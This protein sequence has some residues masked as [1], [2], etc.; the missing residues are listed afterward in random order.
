MTESVLW[1]TAL[2]MFAGG[3]ALLFM[4]KRRNETEGVMSLAH[5]IVP[6]I[7]GCLY[8][9]MA[10]GQGAVLLPTDATLAGAANT[11]RIFWFGRYID[12]VFTTP[13]L[14]VSLGCLGMLQGRK[15][16]DLL[17]G[18]V[19]A[20][21]LMIVTAFA[22][23]A[24]ENVVS[25]WIWFILSCVA[26]LGVYYVIWVSQMEAN[27]KE[28]AEVQSAYKRSATILSVLWMV[29]PVILAISPDG[30]GLVADSVSVLVIAI[31]DVL[32]KVAFGFLSLSDDR[33]LERA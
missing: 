18:A 9:A 19:T 8:V 11:T 23:S 10:T 3:T 2:I 7:A 28:S 5:G 30:L 17:L 6:I 29:Y 13:L 33:K 15:R 20:D 1:I 16:A 31:T 12:W 22:F 25:R 27:R 21:V 4:G 14:L 24:S 26:F 32:A